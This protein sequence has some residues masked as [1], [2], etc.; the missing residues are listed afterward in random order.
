MNQTEKTM[1]Q[2][3]AQRRKALNMTQERLA[4]ELGVTA[5]AVSK[6]ENDLSCPD[7]SILPRLTRVLGITADELITGQ[8]PEYAP[9]PGHEPE[10]EPVDD[11]P[12]IY[13]ESDN[14]RKFD[15][16]FGAP[17]R[18]GFSAALWLICLGGLMLAGPLLALEAVSFWNAV[19][20]SGL[21]VF[22]VSGMLRRIRFSNIIAALAGVYFAL[23][24]LGLVKLDL[25]WEIL[26][27]AL[28]VLLGVSL[29]FDRGRKHAR[30]IHVT[31]R[32]GQAGQI[33][34]ENGYLSYSDSFGEDS[35][36]V[37]APELTG[38]DISV[39]FGEHELDFSGVER[40]SEN[41]VIEVNS[42]FGE[43]TLRIPKRFRV[44]LN[45]SKNFAKMEIHGHP[46]PEPQGVI[47]L[48]VD[49]NFGELEVQYV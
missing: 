16:H 13:V 21:F 23:E 49:V 2:R 47:T 8:A 41:C 44:D 3:I 1:G 17:R 30:G 24:G 11:R 46:D 31:S 28:I 6:W 35:Y 40:V 39:S 32:A 37:S 15:I 25:G 7:I 22:G 5:Q 43:L 20:I 9:E 36:L 38:G 48:D 18:A 12:G 4:N 26:F 33:S 14:G 42:S 29:L 27:P 19:W 45:S 10:P 34:V